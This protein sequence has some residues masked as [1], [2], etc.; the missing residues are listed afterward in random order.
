M[1]YIKR[2]V[3]NGKAVL[4]CKIE[5]TADKY[6]TICEGRKILVPKPEGITDIPEISYRGLKLGKI[7]IC[8]EIMDTEKCSTRSYDG[9][10]LD[11]LLHTYGKYVLGS[12]VEFR[13]SYLN[14]LELGVYDERHLELL[15]HLDYEFKEMTVKGLI[16]PQE[17]C[18]QS[19]ESP[20]YNLESFTV[21]DSLKSIGI[22][23]KYLF[24]EEDLY[25]STGIHYS[26]ILYS[27]RNEDYVLYV[28]AVLRLIHGGSSIQIYKDSKR[29]NMSYAS[30]SMCMSCDNEF[31]GRLAKV[32]LLSNTSGY[33]EI[34]EK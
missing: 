9:R 13:G 4:A 11:N 29:I 18:F 34:R 19:P 26:Y 22:E 12:Y 30:Y 5:S 27:E 20:Y 21:D 15:S 3:Y 17:A 23:Y 25:K 2:I 28:P 7:D 33:A 32:S 6:E 8:V 14:H 16:T 1:K 24:F 31:W 10:E